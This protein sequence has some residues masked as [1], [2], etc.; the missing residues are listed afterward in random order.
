MSA[1]H[2]VITGGS[3]G[4]G[5]GMAL[6]YLQRGAYVS[7]LDQKIKDQTTEMLNRV[8]KRHGGNW[9]FFETD[10]RYFQCME[11]AVN[12][13]TQCYGRVHIAINSAG[14]VLNK[15]IADMKPEE[16]SQVITVNLV[17]S[18]NFSA[19]VLPFL[20]KG[21]QLALVASLAGI[22]SNYGYSAYG[23][24]K[25][26]VVGLATALRY[27]Y[28]MQGFSVSCI[29]PPEVNTP[30]VDQE[31]LN[32]NQVSLELKKIAGSMGV[33][34]ACDQILEGLDAKRWMIIPSNSGK[35]TAWVARCFPGAFH[36]F[37][38]YLIRRSYKRTRIA[39]STG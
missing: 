11:S 30:L 37:I 25:F 3:S 34:D 1:Q 5:L 29:C 13:A 9:C 16:F 27:E 35:L 18:Y 23:A 12:T 19:T 10:V 15:V 6:R 22:T 33:N 17:G 14:I 4:L 2:V 36:R 31:R 20:E 24:S 7:I 21:G 26:G 8:A 32:G 38:S 28:E 39:V